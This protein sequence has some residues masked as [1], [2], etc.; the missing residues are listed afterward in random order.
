MSISYCLAAAKYIYKSNGF[1]AVVHAQFKNQTCPYDV[2]K[3]DKWDVSLTV[4]LAQFTNQTATSALVL[5]NSNTR[6]PARRLRSPIHKST[7][8]CFIVE[9]LLTSQIKRYSVRVWLR[10]IHKSSIF[11]RPFGA[12][13]LHESDASLTTGPD[14]AHFTNQTFPFLLLPDHQRDVSFNTEPVPYSQIRPFSSPSDWCP[15][16]RSDWHRLHHQSTIA[17][18]GDQTGI[19]FITNWPLSYSDIRLTTFSNT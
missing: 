3:Y 16:H 8:S 6:R 12:C 7:G 5:F 9:S 1:V 2:H 11:S 19:V 18:L 14:P 15:I 4:V 10:S 13:T 17:L